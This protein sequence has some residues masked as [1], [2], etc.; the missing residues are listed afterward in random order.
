MITI[1]EKKTFRNAAV[2]FLRKGNHCRTPLVDNYEM[3]QIIHVN[4]VYLFS[5][6]YQDTGKEPI[7]FAILCEKND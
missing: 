4:G 3:L 5:F 7:Y 1:V 6:W 2:S